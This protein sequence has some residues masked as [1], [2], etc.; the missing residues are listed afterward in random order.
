MQVFNSLPCAY[1]S[2]MSPVSVVIPAYNRVQLLPRALDSV[3][4]QTC[5]ATEI[6]VVDDGSDDGTEEMIY[7]QYPRVT[8]LRQAHTGVSTARN[9][10]IRS[11]RHDWIALLDSDDEWHPRKLS[12]QT[13]MLAENPDYKLVHTDEIWI[14]NGRRVNPMKKHR[15]YGGY[16][17][18]HCLPLCAI[19]P[20]SVLV[21]RDIFSDVGLFDESLPAC[22]DYDLWLRICCKYPVLFTSQKLTIKYGG[23]DDQ[24]SRQHWGMDR[25]R[26]RTIARLLADHELDDHLRPLA[27]GTLREKCLIYLAGAEKRGNTDSVGEFTALLKRYPATETFA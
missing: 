26:I 9:L 15:K 18:H 19:S 16:I 8:Y 7:Q 22:E 17:F 5:Q 4:A 1:H 12:V 6:I 25:F 14:R 10:G 20:S 2:I 13:G 27:I 23:H 3:L 24:L 11:A 21:H